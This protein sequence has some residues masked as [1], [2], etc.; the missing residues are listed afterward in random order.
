[1]KIPIRLLLVIVL[2]FA[3]AVPAS[4]QVG[5]G[6]LNRFEVQR[7]VA[8]D[9]AEAHAALA[10]HFIA[11]AHIYR[12]D[13]ARYTALAKGYVGNP[14]HPNGTTVAASWMRKAEDATANANAARAVV[15]YHQ[16]LSLGRTT[17]R[18][19]D[20]AAFD[21][22][23]GA[24]PPTPAEVDTLVNAARTPQAHRELVE[25]FLVAERAEAFNA[26]AYTR[27][28]R[29]ARVSGARNTDV[30]AARYDHLA[31]VAR[32]TA[33]RANLAVELHRQLAA[34]A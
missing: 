33:R 24:P 17:R 28:A 16:I 10:R 3:I 11:L 29:M 27:M 9:T 2:A 25:Y 14:N 22:G 13:A 34:I 7:L 30:I 32:E 21:G 18:P 4:A 8:I 5:S 26:E 23:K 6:M 1:M 12:S 19:A 31:S 20:A 15:A